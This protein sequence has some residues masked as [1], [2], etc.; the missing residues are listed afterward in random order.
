MAIITRSVSPL[1]GSERPFRYV[2]EPHPASMT[3]TAKAALALIQRLLFFKIPTLDR[4]RGLKPQHRE[5]DGVSAHKS[6]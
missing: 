2:V 1:G 6:T 4:C 3:A 5:I